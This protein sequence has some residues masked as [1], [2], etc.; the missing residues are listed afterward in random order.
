MRIDLSDFHLD[1][2]AISEYLRENSRVII[3]TA[4]TVFLVTAASTLVVFALV[5]KGSEQVMVPDVQG[6]DISVA[7]LE[8]QAKELYPRVQLRY[9]DKMDDKGSILEQNPSPGSIVKAGRRINLVISRGVIIDRIEN[10]VGQNLDEVKMQLQAMFTS[11][12]TP[13]IVITEPPLYRFS[14]EPAGTI[15]EQKPAPDTPLAGPT[16]VELVVSRGPE[17]DRVTVPD[18]TGRSIREMYS[19][20]EKTNL[21]YDFSLR[22]PEGSER[23]GTIVSQMPAGEARIN[24]YSRISTVLAVPVAN[25]EGK[26]YGI[27]SETLPEYPYP[28]QIKLSAISPNGERS[29]LVS[30]KHP[31]G[32]FSVP[33][34]LEEGT[35]L[36]LTILNKEVGTREVHADTD[37]SQ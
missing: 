17:G 23:A 14:E 7:L 8:L 25:P 16:K 37:E 24:S 35:V 34:L 10:Y 9:S 30:V 31:G 2:D 13:L 26:V 19:I 5:L 32:N 1:L 33:Y 3:L 11:M 27:F 12:A 4:L 28:F 21:V 18:I 6:K 15:L 20:M 36:V 22:N 29:P